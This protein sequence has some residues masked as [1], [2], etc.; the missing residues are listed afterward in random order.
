MGIFDIFKRKGKDGGKEPE[1]VGPEAPD[2][3]ARVAETMPRDRDGKAVFL[4]DVV[5]YG[6]K[7]FDVVAV[8]HRGRIAIRKHGADR[9]AGAFWTPSESVARMGDGSEAE[10]AS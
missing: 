5:L 1:A 3:N 4:D 10:H 9:G 8:S 7:P 2:A 6:K